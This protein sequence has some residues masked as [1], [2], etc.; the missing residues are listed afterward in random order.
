[1]KQQPPCYGCKE[2]HLACHDSCDRFISFRQKIDDE[3]AKRYFE[4]LTYHVYERR[5]KHGRK[6][7]QREH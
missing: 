5:D 4:T 3:N 6:V 2:R 1:M 7:R